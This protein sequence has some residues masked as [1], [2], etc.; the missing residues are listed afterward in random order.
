MNSRNETRPPPISQITGDMPRIDGPSSVGRIH[1]QSEEN[2]TPMIASPMASAHRSEPSRSR[3]GR[4]STGVSAMRRPNRTIPAPTITSPAK[5]NL[6]EAYVVA[7][8][9]ISGPTAI[10]MAPAAPTRP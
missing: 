3:C 9:P 6:H 1:P 4:T 2:S 7:R 8:P 5:T 10:A